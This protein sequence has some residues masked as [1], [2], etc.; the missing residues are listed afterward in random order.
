M[1][2]GSRASLIDML[3]MDGFIGATTATIGTRMVTISAWARPRTPPR[4][5]GR[6][7]AEAQRMMFDGTIARTA[8]PACGP[9][10]T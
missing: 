2:E 6:K 1:R 9:S 7:H 10:T 5:E 4:D 8:T 3:K